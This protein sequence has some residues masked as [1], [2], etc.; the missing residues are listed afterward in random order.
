MVC[1]SHIYSRDLPDRRV[2]DY[3]NLELKQLLDIV[4]SFLM[5]DDSGLL[6]D[7]Y[8]TTEIGENDATRISVMDSGQFSIWLQAREKA[9]QAISDF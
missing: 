7:A 2:R 1:F 5:T 3:D 9:L 6:C 8:N 4:A